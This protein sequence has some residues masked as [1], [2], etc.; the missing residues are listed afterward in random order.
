MTEGGGIR[1]LGVLEV[2]VLEKSL[3]A[4]AERP[5]LRYAVYVIGTLMGSGVLH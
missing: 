3:F 5:L 2:A 4:F 1:H